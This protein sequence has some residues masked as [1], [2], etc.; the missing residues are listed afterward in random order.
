MSEV[1]QAID[2]ERVR[3]GVTARSKK[4]VL[5]ILSAL[6]AAGPTRQT[7]PEIFAGLNER[8]RLGSTSLGNGVA[9]PHYRDA[10]LATPTAALLI[11]SDAVN[12]DTS[13]DD[14]IDI[15]LGILL[16]PGDG[17]QYIDALTHV[18]SQRDCVTMLRRAGSPESICAMLVA[19]LNEVNNAPA[20]ISTE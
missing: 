1:A 6:L 18:L 12:F 5:E 2:P 4:H 7:A 15:V 20:A 14:G 8:E 19:R 16:P 11:L 17:S 13:D 3:C 10:E 9:V